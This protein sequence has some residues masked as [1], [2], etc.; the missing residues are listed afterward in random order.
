MDQLAKK[1]LLKIS[2]INRE[3]LLIIK[4][5]IKD[6]IKTFSRDKRLESINYQIPIPKIRYAI[7]SLGIKK[8]DILLVHSSVGKFFHGSLIQQEPEF[9][10]VIEYSK[11]IIDMLIDLLGKNGTLVF[12]TDSISTSLSTWSLKKKTFNYLRMPSRRGWLSEVFRQHKDILRSVHPMYNVST[13]GKEAYNLIKDNESSKPFT[14]DRNS[15]W[16]KF[17]KLKGKILLLGVTHDSN[18]L[19][20]LPEYLFPEDFP[21]ALYMHKPYPIRYINKEGIKKTMNLM[22][23]N[24]SYGHDSVEKFIK[25]LEKKFNFSLFCELDKIPIKVVQSEKLLNILISEMK[26]GNCWQLSQITGKYPE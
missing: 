2:K 18:S 24:V 22:V 11:A 16:Y 23:H 6:I 7:E 25:P 3:R 21:M 14:M 17:T 10:N 5:C 9:P 12:P 8:G 13:Y 26:K 20:H 1:Q 15:P 4:N 19:V